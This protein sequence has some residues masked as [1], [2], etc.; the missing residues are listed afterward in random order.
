M[1]GDFLYLIGFVKLMLIILKMFECFVFF[2]GSSLGGGVVI[3][4]V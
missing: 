1:C 4:M 2:S 3:V